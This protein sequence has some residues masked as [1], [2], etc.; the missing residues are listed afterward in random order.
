MTSERLRSEWFEE[1][2]QVMDIVQK[3]YPELRP[4]ARASRAA[5]LLGESRRLAR[6]GRRREAMRRA[7]EAARAGGP[8]GLAR[9]AGHVLRAS[10]ER[11]SAVAAAGTAHHAALG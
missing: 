6:A 9:V 1:G 5:L 2:L 8:G 4:R 11:R 10:R 3:R 7:V